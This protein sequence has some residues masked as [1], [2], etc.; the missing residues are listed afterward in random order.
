MFFQAVGAVVVGVDDAA[1]RFG[2][3]EHGANQLAVPRLAH[4]LGFRYG[5]RGRIADDGD[6]FIDIG[7][8][9]GQ[10][11]Q[12]MATLTGFAQVEDGAASDHFATVRQKDADEVFQVAQTWLTVDQGHHVHAK[13]VLQLGLFVEVV[14]DHLGHRTALELNHQAHAGFVRLILDVADV[15]NLLF[16]HQFGHALLQRLFVHLIRQ[17]INDDGLALAFVDVF[18]VAFGSHDHASAARAIAF[19]HA[20][21]AIDDAG[22][23]EVGG[24]HDVHQVINGGIGV[25]QHVQASVHHLVQ[26]MRRDVGG[27]ADR[28]T[29]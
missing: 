7:Q 8:S 11:F 2:A 24:R 4:Q 22:G 27:H 19:F 23:G 29:S 28:N 15:L 20:A 18:K 13:S 26:V 3:G 10:A 9:Y 12:H 17:L 5:W 21:D 14:Q 6:E 1:I 25:A 16:V